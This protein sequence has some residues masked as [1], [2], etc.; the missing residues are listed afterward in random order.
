MGALAWD[1]S[2]RHREE[3]HPANVALTPAWLVDRIRNDLFDGVIH[4]DPAT[5][6]DNPTA[7]ERFVALPQDGI[8]TPWEGPNIYCNPPYGATAGKWVKKSIFAAGGGQ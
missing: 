7:A 2:L 4:L 8:L 6:P 1:N 5:E 3:S